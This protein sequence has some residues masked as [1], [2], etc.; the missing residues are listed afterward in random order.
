MYTSVPQ[1]TAMPRN[2]EVDIDQDEEAEHEDEAHDSAES[3][4]DAEESEEEDVGKKKR[5]KLAPIEF[6]E[7]E[8]WN[9]NDMSDAD[10][11]AHIRGHLFEMNKDAGILH[12][13]GSHKDRV[14]QF[15]DWIFRRR[16]MSNQGLVTN[17]IVNCPLIKRCNCP[18]Q[19]KIVE[20]PTI[21]TLYV[22][23]LHTADDHVTAKDK[24]K[25]LNFREKTVIRDAVKIAPN[26]SARELMRNV[27]DSPTKTISIAKQKSVER[28]VR[29]ERLRLV[30]VQ[31]EGVVV[32][33]SIGSLS[34]LADAMWF[35]DA[36]EK[37]NAGECLDLFKVY[38][39]GK[40]IMESDRT[41]FLTF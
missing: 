27:A 9:R 10:I 8:S 3:G 23:N 34:Q 12:M 7:V 24:S 4:K 25:Y 41:V 2:F 21:T 33:N 19:C 30:S 11:H 36:L 37:H 22:A 35:G 20:K 32:D 31:L 40:H 1:T 5:A 39:I 38:I 26:Q 16:W 18:C 29:T 14:N 28:M 6:Q 17:V 15:G 13:P